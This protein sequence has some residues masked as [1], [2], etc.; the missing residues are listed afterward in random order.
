[1]QA[2]KSIWQYY[3][4]TRDVLGLLET[5]KKMVNDSIG[6]GLANNATSLRRLSL[7]SYN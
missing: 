7:L 6:V 3:V 1:V 2:L 5:F 4:P